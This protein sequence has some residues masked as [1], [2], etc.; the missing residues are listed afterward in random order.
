[1]HQT[2]RALFKAIGNQ[3]YQGNNLKPLRFCGVIRLDEKECAKEEDVK[4]FLLNQGVMGTSFSQS[5][6]VSNL[7]FLLAM[8]AFI[9]PF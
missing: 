5:T 7:F 9:C 6:Q 1:M 3:Q 4:E 8:R 2:L